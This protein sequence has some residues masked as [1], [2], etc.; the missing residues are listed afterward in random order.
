MTGTAAEATDSSRRCQTAWGKE[1][2]APGGA[3][4]EGCSCRRW[5]LRQSAQSEQR[6]NRIVANVGQP[7]A[8]TRGCVAHCGCGLVQRCADVF[9]RRRGNI[10][11]YSWNERILHRRGAIE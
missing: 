9:P 4:G 7:V 5:L 1:I 6:V 3:E 10:G 8:F 11:R 2:R